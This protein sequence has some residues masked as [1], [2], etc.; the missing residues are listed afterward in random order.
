MKL[1]FLPLWLSTQQFICRGDIVDDQANPSIICFFLKRSK[2]DQ[3]GTGVEV[4]IGKTGKPVC[5]VT[6]VLAYLSSRGDGPGPFFKDSHGKPLTKSMFIREVRSALTSMGLQA[7]PFAGHSFRIGAATAAAQAGL[8][9]SVIQALGRWSSATFLLYIRI[10][11]EQLAPLSA[12]IA[13][14]CS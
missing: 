1:Q 11:R 13:S 14:T 5:P 7:N 9:D 12:L 2:C 8:E 4:F 3:F 6:A 10:P